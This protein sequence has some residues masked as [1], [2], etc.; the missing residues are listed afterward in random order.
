MSNNISSNDINKAREVIYKIAGI[1]LPPSKDS[2]IKNRLD[3][4]KRKLGI[5]DFEA[6]FNQ[7]RVGQ[8]KQEFINAFTTN[9]TDFF[10]EGFHFE[11]M[12][13]R[14]LPHRLRDSEPLKVYCSASSTGEE[15]YSIATTLLYAKDIYRSSTPV[16]V[17]ATDI[18]TSVLEFAKKGKYLVNTKLN[19]LPN[20]LD[21]KD[22]FEMRHKSE[23]EVFMD[24]KQNLKNILTFKQ[25]NLYDARYPFGVKEFDIIFCRNVL[26]YFKVSDQEQILSKMFSHLKIGGTLYLGHSESILN[27]ASK[28]D[29]LG[30]NTF[31]KIMD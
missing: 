30:K 25:H 1:Y 28:V 4:L 5:Q 6:F 26:I 12:L 7:V 22:Y 8:F 11:D 31:I 24:A 13:N 17:L 18:D 21:L 15:P 23:N 27:L 2:T 29:R 10:R 9:K 16:S 19:P 14:I 20:W 3:I